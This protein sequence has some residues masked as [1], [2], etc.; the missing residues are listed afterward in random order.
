MKSLQ[1]HSSKRLSSSPHHSSRAR[2]IRCSMSQRPSV[3]TSKASLT[4]DDFAFDERPVILFDGV[5]VLCNSAVD[6]MLRWDEKGEFRL[7][8]LQSE[9]GQRL[10]R[11]CG[12]EPN[13]ISSIVLVEKNGHYI[14]SESVLRIASKLTNPLPFLAMFGLVVPLFVRD[15]AYEL[16]ADNRYYILGKKD[17]CRMMPKDPK[18]RSRFVF[19]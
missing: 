19:E 8:A 7:S 2:V 3:A 1:L 13:D 17:S 10:L 12:R 4:T 18:E 16:V 5:C 6:F 15:K 14:K 9:A 11:R